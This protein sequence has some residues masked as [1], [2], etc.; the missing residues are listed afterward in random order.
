MGRS[1]GVAVFLQA[2]LGSTRLPGKALKLLAGI[3]STGQAMKRLKEIPV[4][5]YVLLTDKKS[6]SA[7]TPEAEKWGFEIMEGSENDVLKRFALAVEK[8]VPHTFIRATGDNP[9]VFSEEATL[10]LKDHLEKKADHS[11]FTGMP[12][13]AGVEIVKAEKI[14]E[15]DKY[16]KDPYEREHVTPYLY[17]RKIEFYL[18]HIEAPASVVFPDGRITMDTLEDYNYLKKIFEKWDESIILSSVKLV[19]ML[20]KNPHPSFSDVATG[21]SYK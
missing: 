12:L 15:A 3:S 9:L 17:K 19:K 8:Y 21:T 6:F 2:R 10:I 7:L 20:K 14:I 18:N 1:R 4:E 13:G 11:W 5:H 16:A